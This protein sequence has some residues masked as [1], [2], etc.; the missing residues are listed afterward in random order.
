MN[1]LP[2][3]IPFFAPARPAAGASTR[4]PLSLSPL[5][6]AARRLRHGF[7][8]Y[9]AHAR[10]AERIGQGRAGG[11][12]LAADAGERALARAAQAAA[13]T[14]GLQ[15]HPVQ[16]AAAHALLS[17]RFGEMATGEGKTL[18]VAL[19]AAAGAL[20]GRRVHAITANDY[21]VARD[22]ALMAPLYEALGVTVG[23]VVPTCTAA[24]RATAYRADITYVTARELVFDSLREAVEAPAPG[25]LLA[26]TRRF[27]RALPAASTLCHHDMAIIDEADSVLIDDARVP[28][29]LSEALPTGADAQ[30]LEAVLTAAR[31]CIEGRH[32]CRD[33]GHGLALNP[34]GQ[35]LADQL[36]GEPRLNALRLSQALC[37]L[38]LYRRD[39]DYLV[40]DD[41][42][43]IIDRQTGRLA[44]GRSWSQELHRFIELKEGC[45][46][47]RETRTRAQMTYQRF[48]ARYR[49][50]C[51]V[52][53]T[54]AEA[55]AEL[56]AIYDRAMVRIPTHRPVRRVV[57]PPRLFAD[58]EALDAAC[59]ARARQLQADGRAVLI[60]TDSVAQARRLS[61]RLAA[62]GIA[63]RVLDAR[64]ADA[65]ARI[66]A[67]AGQAGSV[68]IATRM[69]GRGTDIPLDA[70]VRRQ[71]GLH[72]ICAQ[73]NP[74]PRIDRQLVGRC[75]RQGDP[76]S[77]EHFQARDADALTAIGMP[78]GSRLPDRLW[79][80]RLRLARWR[81][82]VGARQ[83]RLRML[84]TDQLHH[85]RHTYRGTGP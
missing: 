14:L 19:A 55:A 5:A 27:V 21:L 66:V 36:P 35:A 28:L 45:P 25:D 3:R 72:V 47:G 30:C 23:H 29:I 49:H 70:A 83:A 22:A 13:D 8:R 4:A 40:R 65:E 84:R 71:G 38:H 6:I 68:T 75:A 57:G 16:L 56:A 31:D 7:A 51:G 11:V 37:A 58:A 62:A 9:G 82:A 18:V 77:A 54:L 79:Q 64:S 50:L 73:H 81:S 85:R 67:A 46:L 60:G 63:H 76:G 41:Q 69:A 80:L 34:A 33:A 1:I 61:G 2:L 39:V 48:F 32:F 42:V 53:G 43:H 78:P 12:P 15:P 74:D 10:A 20:M 59:A 17:G 26:G 52:S 44:E 24:G